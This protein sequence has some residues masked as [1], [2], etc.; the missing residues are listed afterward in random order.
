MRAENVTVIFMSLIG[1]QYRQIISDIVDPALVDWATKLEKEKQVSHPGVAEGRLAVN[2]G[3][4]RVIFEY[5]PTKLV[6]PKWAEAPAARL[7]PF[8]NCQ[9]IDSWCVHA[10]A[11]AYAISKALDVDPTALDK[12]FNTPSALAWIDAAFSA[13]SPSD[14]KK[15]YKTLSFCLHPDRKQESVSFDELQGAW[16]KWNPE[17]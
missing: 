14:R 8:C 13:V 17:K 7:V 10:V 9:E 12:I 11:A 5:E 16:L 2:V 15:L 3:T 6:D 1:E 4:H